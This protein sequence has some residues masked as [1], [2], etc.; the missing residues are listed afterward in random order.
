MDCVEI[1]EEDHLFP[2]YS[3]VFGR[4]VHHHDCR[5]YECCDV[6][7]ERGWLKQDRG[8]DL[9]IPRIADGL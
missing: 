7:D 9:D 5:H 8:I 6:H 1:E 4:D 3:R 2:A